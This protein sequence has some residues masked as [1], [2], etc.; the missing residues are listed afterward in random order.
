MSTSTTIDGAATVRTPEGIATLFERWQ[1]HGDRRAQETLFE[2]FKPLARSLARRYASTREP[3]DD[4]TQVAYLGLINAIERFDPTRG[5][6]FAAFAVPTILG[7]LRRYFRDTAWAVHV[8]RGAQERSLE[9]EQATGQLTSDSGHAP[10]VGEIAQYLECDH[11]QVLE[12][13]QVRQARNS[14]SLD[15]PRPGAGD[16]EDSESRVSTIG[17]EDEGYELVEDGAAVAHAL[18]SLAPRER[19]ILQLRFV[20]EMTQSEIA[21]QIGL[22]QMQISRVLRQSLERMQRIAEGSPH[23]G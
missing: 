3:M 11:E 4:L 10:T 7:E 21:E 5:N 20:E 18:G 19:R 16:E 8:P 9:V 23:K 14:V 12:A 13:M 22:S 17:A 15:A 6:R 1:T 2:S